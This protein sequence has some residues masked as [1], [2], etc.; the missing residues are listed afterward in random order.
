[1]SEVFETRGVVPINVQLS[2]QWPEKQEKS[3]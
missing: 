1:M 3:S 2:C